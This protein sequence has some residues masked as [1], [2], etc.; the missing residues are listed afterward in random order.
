MLLQD[1]DCIG[2]DIVADRVWLPHPSC[3]P[4][5]A[6][7]FHDSIFPKEKE[8]GEDGGVVDALDLS[9]ILN[10]LDGV[11]ETPGRVL[12]MTS[13]WPERLDKALTRNG[14][15]DIL[16]E[17]KKASASI[18]RGMYQLHFDAPWPTEREP[19]DGVLTPAA[20]GGVLFNNFCNPEKAVDE[21]SR[22]PA[23]DYFPSHPCDER[24]P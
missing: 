6:P 5:S 12:V 8:T 7:Q 14:R 22:V 18:I 21:L 20:V 17:F 15:I 16:M 1:I 24:A 11:L 10:A 19:K 23:H 9:S 4:P 13:N 2:S 3:P